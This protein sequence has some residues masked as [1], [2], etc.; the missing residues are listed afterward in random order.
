MMDEE[1]I[2]FMVLYPSRGLFAAAI[3]DL[4]G[5]IASA[6]GR[7]YDRWLADYCAENERLKGMALVPLH[8]PTRAA[9]DAVWAVDELGLTG[10]M[11]RPNPAHGRNLHD[12]AYDD[13]YSTL[14]D[15]DVPLSVHEGCGVFMPQYGIDRFEEHIIW[16]AMCHP[17]EQMGAV[18][19][20]TLGGIWERHP[21]LDVA[22]L[23]SGAGWLPYWLHRLDEHVEWLGEIETPELTATPTEYFRRRGYIGM[24]GDEPALRAVVDAVGPDR[25]LWASDYPHPD[26]KYPGMVD[27][28]LEV[29]D[30]T[31]AEQGLILGDNPRRFYRLSS[32]DD[33]GDEGATASM[34]S[35]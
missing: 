9:A 25:L 31:S 26:A 33:A 12:A 15:L 35:S 11:V 4:D 6:I 7:A 3:G 32:S 8:D 17:M 21:Q 14:E 10:V 16:H 30:L 29:D 27:A 2:D 34:V 18:V 5:S 20:F 13:F 24:E 22:F 23:E 28:F 19:S 1:G